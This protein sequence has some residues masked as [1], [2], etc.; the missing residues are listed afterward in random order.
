MNYLLE[1]KYNYSILLFIILLISACDASDT[2][3]YDNEI[4]KITT[5]KDI[6]PPIRLARAD[7][8][9]LPLAR[10][11]DNFSDKKQKEISHLISENHYKKLDFNNIYPQTNNALR[12]KNYLHKIDPYS[13]Y[14]SKQQYQFTRKRSLLKR[15][16]AGFNL[17]I[18]K[19]KVLLVPL[20]QTALY[21]AGL[22][23]PKYLNSIN[24]KK[25]HY[26]N[27]SSY[28]FLTQIKSGDA[29][30]ISVKD[31]QSNQNETYTVRA[32]TYHRKLDYYREE[33]DY[34]IIRIDE[35][36]EGMPKN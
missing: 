11:Q 14:L 17:L 25:I 5:V 18:N 32:K 4:I 35:F 15:V 29:I 30:D 21:Q 28:A 36:R 9:P 31:T 8:L 2:P 22:T 7:P 20:P 34:S 24:Q 27:F 13:K 19:D 12:L 33:K 10:K 1:I 16:G 6:N 3:L 26:Q 23:I